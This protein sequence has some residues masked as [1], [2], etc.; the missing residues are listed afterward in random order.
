MR[1]W[2]IALVCVW[3]ALVGA[4]V[5]VQ[6]SPTGSDTN[7]GTA[8]A[9][10]ATL[11][12]ARDLVRERRNGAA[13]AQIVLADGLYRL[14]EP[15]RLGPADR[16]LT[17][18]AAPG[19]RP[20]LSGGR[21]VSGW[22]PWRGAVLQ[23]DLR[24][25]ALPDL[26]FRELYRAGQRQPLARVP[27]Y[28]PAHPRHGGW[29]YNAGVAE[30]ETKTRFLYRAGELQPERWSH[31][32]RGWVVFHPAVNYERKW[33]PL[34]S[35]D[36]TARVVEAAS[37]V[38]PLRPHDRWFVC[39]LLAEL[40]A[41]G[42]WYVDP[43]AARL[44][45]QP[46]AEGPGEVLVPALES[47]LVVQ[48]DPAAA[49]TGI[50][51]RGLE[52][53]ETRGDAISISQARDIVVAACAL[54]NVGVAVR[55]GLDTADC[56]VVGCDITQTL[57]DGIAITGE[58][59]NYE[60]VRGHRI[61][62]NYIWDFGWG[63]LHNRC[64][65]VWLTG[66]T[67]CQITHNLI[68]DGPRYAIGMDVGRNIEIAWNHGHDVNIDT[69]DTGIIEAATAY[70]WGWPD[71]TARNKSVNRGNRIHHN[72]VHGSGGIDETGPGQ[73][74]YPHFSWGIYLDT[75]CSGWE[76]HDNIAYD[77]VLGG[78]MLNCGEDN[79]VV[80]NVFVGGQESQV[81]FNPW[82]KYV[83][84]NNRCERN[85]ISYDGQ[86]AN[87][88]T[89][90]GFQDSFV[91]FAANLVHS[92]DGSVR[93]RGPQGLKARSAWADWQQRGQDAGSRLANPLFRD[94]ARHDYRLQPDS[95]AL[96]LGH[97]PIDLTAAGVYESP[98]R[99]TW[100]R[101]EEPV[102]REPADYRAAARSIGQPARRD[103]EDYALG[104]AERGA[105]V[106]VKDA[107]RVAVV[108]TTAASGRQSLRVTDAAGLPQAFVPY[109]TYPLELLRGTLRSGLSLRWEAGAKLEYEWRDDPYQYHLGPQLRVEPDGRAFANGT[110]LGVLPA[111]QWVR[112]EATCRLGDAATG[113]YDLTWTV[114]GAAPRLLHELPCHPEFGTL[115]CVVLMSSADAAT[116]FYVD[117]VTFEPLP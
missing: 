47:L 91:R 37:G 11:A 96:A 85:V 19:A 108:A 51:I 103:Y 18:Q 82:P 30:P 110:P 65:G 81:Q 16:G 1:R 14:A 46:P 17:L 58:A 95:P 90:N 56:R 43:E 101:P 92:A 61:D 41:P 24:G 29:L 86:A 80:N 84:A 33:A 88:Y 36:A 66:A 111:G 105:H 23:A 115:A 20:V 53:R 32:E 54:R 42:E 102:L 57:G 4:Q 112:W 35:A 59:R 45:Y 113:K 100:P 117:D 22:Q 114:P 104:E 93:I 26:K 74:A 44:Y 15:L 64:G 116:V 76:V 3:P 99:R 89:L 9:P 109:I 39:G 73:V 38:Y 62:N 28:D 72:L 6:V 71:E 97:Q 87:L 69:C 107:A 94:A 75:H 27:N 21:P 31:L 50:V 7:P 40:D 2:L 34:K 55:L 49:V 52:L 77:T 60:R 25:L 10:V 78:F 5:V 12:R 8:A 70:N 106:G 63:N 79:A 98:D 48:G 68:H 83:I 13:T 67:D